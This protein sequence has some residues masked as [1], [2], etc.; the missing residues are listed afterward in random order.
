MCMCMCICLCV[1]VYVYVFVYVYVSVYVYV[2]VYVYICACVCVCVRV[3]VRVRVHARA[4]VHFRVYVRVHAFDTPQTMVSSNRN[5][6]HLIKF[7][8]IFIPRKVCTRGTARPG[9]FDSSIRAS[10]SI[11][12]YSQ[13]PFTSVHGAL[14]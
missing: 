5:G 1:Y 14:K 7:S 13:G 2:Y 4:H 3:C 6:F 11:R 12:V 8:S 9:T 10:V